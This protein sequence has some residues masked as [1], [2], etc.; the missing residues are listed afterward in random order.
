[1]TAEKRYRLPQRFRDVM[2]EHPHGD[3]RRFPDEPSRRFSPELLFMLGAI[4][5]ALGQGWECPLSQ[6]GERFCN[7]CGLC[8]VAKAHESYCASE[9]RCPDGDCDWLITNYVDEDGMSDAELR[10][11]RCG[12]LPLS[13]RNPRLR[14]IEPHT[15]G[16]TFGPPPGD[17]KDEEPKP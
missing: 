1:M 11:T 4:R 9:T 3:W 14:S 2:E 15:R 13:L 8:V 7:G 10:C 17:A 5:G 16:A 6:D 12:L